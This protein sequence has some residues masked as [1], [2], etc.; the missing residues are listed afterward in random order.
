[1]NL[2]EIKWDNANTYDDITTMVIQTIQQ[3]EPCIGQLIRFNQKNFIINKIS[4]AVAMYNSMLPQQRAISV[5]GI[6][7]IAS[8]FAEHP[9]VKNL[10]L[11]EMKSF[12]KMAFQQHRFGKI[13]A[14]FGYDTLIDWFNLF[15]EQRTQ[16]VI[17]FRENQHQ[18]F[19][20]FEKQRR[21]RSEGD[22]FGSVG[23][24]INRN[25]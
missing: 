18:Q 25:I 22:A 13:Y 12:F 1:M 11:S 15:F 14:G 5:Q 21:T 19:T 17:E 24:I 16:A 10:S 6:V 3:D 2:C 4:E 9:D 8:S 20:M 23:E 7:N